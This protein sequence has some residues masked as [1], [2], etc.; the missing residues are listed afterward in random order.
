MLKLETKDKAIITYD[1]Q[2]KGQVKLPLCYAGKVKGICGDCNG[3][4]DDFRLE[5]GH[6]VTNRS[7]KFG[8]IGESYRVPDHTDEDIR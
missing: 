1:G 8:L 3:I 2:Q 4:H 5:N 7:T 6:D